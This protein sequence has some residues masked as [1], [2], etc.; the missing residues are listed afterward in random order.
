M[1]RRLLWTLLIALLLALP[2][3][4]AGAE[5]ADVWMYACSVGKADAILVGAGESVCLIDAGYAHSRGKILAAME[6]MGVEKLDAVFVTHTDDDHT[7]GLEWLAESDIE[8]GTWY[9]SAMFIGVK[10]SKHPAVKAAQAR[11]QEVVWLKSGD[12]VPLGHA[13]LEVLAPISLNLDKDDNNSLVM[14]L[15][16]A[17]GNILL[18]G[19]MEL[20]EEAEL[21]AGGADL[22]CD[23]LKVGNH[24]DDDTTGEPLIRASSPEVAVISTSTAEKAETPDPRVVA[25]LQAAGAKVAVTQECTGGILVRLSDGVAAV[26]RI[27]LPPNYTKMEIARVIPGEDLIT[28]T[29]GG[30]EGVDLGGWYLH[31][32]KGGEMLVLPEGT[33]IA[34]GE[35]L[36]IG[37]QTSDKAFDVLWSDKK[38][39]H[40]S[41]TDLITL[42]DPNGMPVSQMD[43]GY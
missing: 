32:E 27:G 3:C 42:Y 39:I 2:G 7:D 24:A 38:V 15:R 1:Q 31:S 43:N 25:A 30:S 28:L 22:D 8:V 26:E 4:S 36:I 17:A 9:A 14:M 18:A 29:N 20:E 23:V 21:L 41:K 13:D 12:R 16:S 19:D 5:N 33:S 34:P 11:G 6:L 10:E 35:S 40:Q 37:T